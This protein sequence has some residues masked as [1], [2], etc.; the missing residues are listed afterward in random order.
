MMAMMVS[1]ER[2]L[3][4]GSDGNRERQFFT[5]SLQYLTTASGCQVEMDEW[6]ITSYEVE[7]GREIGSGGLYVF[8]IPVVIA[9]PLIVYFV[10]GQVFQGSWNRMKV[11]LKVLIVE[12]GVTPSLLVC[13]ITFYTMFFHIYLG[14]PRLSV[15]RSR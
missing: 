1:L 3:Q 7:F 13:Q 11:A 2:R 15:M 6:M 5:H 14:L 4:I 8:C 12:G 9:Y 10:S